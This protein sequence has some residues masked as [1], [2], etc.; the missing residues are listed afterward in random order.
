MTYEKPEPPEIP[1]DQDSFVEIP[2]QPPETPQVAIQLEAKRP[3]VTYVLAGIT[4]FFFL[5]QMASDNLLGF[6]LPASLGAK[7]NEL[8]LRGQIWRLLTP[9]LLHGSLTH[10]FFNMYALVSIGRNVEMFYGH[11]R[12]L[13]LYLLSGFAGNVFSFLITQNPS[14]GASTSIFGLIAA[15]G[16]FIY[17]NRKFFRNS[18]AMLVN[19]LVV[20]GINLFIV[21]M[22]PNID[23]FGHLGGLIGGAAF[24]W[25][26]GPIWAP[27]KTYLGVLITDSRKNSRTLPVG[28]GVCLLFALG[29]AMKFFF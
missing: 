21:G 11:K 15:E 5:L 26:A 29:S 17:R 14:Y 25:L 24:A 7:I 8:I 28:L 1:D 22:I 4:I 16:V 2:N 3:V 13:V 6:D 27:Q 18:Q 10:I 20:I 23:N 19:I 12:Y 9:I